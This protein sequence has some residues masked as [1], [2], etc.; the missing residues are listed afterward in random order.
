VGGGGCYCLP[1][2]IDNIERGGVAHVGGELGERGVGV[3]LELDITHP[4]RRRWTGTLKGRRGIWDFGLG[5]LLCFALLCFAL[6]LAMETETHSLK[7]SMVLCATTIAI[8]MVYVAS[9]SHLT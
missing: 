3:E 5:E 1:A 9:G 6:L 4:E 7:G 8:A 2:R